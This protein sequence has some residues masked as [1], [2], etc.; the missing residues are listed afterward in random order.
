[1]A[2][3]GDRLFRR[4]LPHNFSE[5]YLIIMDNLQKLDRTTIIITGPTAAGK[6]D[7]AMELARHIPSEIINMDMGQMYTPLSIGTAKPEWRSHPIPHHMFDIIDTPS[8]YT[9][10]EYRKQVLDIMN[11]LWKQKKF[12]LVVGG[13]SFYLKSLFFPPDQHV[14]ENVK[15]NFSQQDEMW[16]HLSTPLLWQELFAIDPT[17]AEKIN[18]N[19]RYRIERA[20]SL[21]RMT[22]KKPSECTLNYMPPSSYILL[23]ITRDRKELYQRI[24]ARVVEM[25]RQGW[26]EEV[27]SLLE[28][29]W[30]SFIQNKKI[31][32]YNELIHFLTSSDQSALAYEAMIAEIQQRSRHYAKRQ[33]TFWRSLCNQLKIHASYH[34]GFK[35]PI[36][37]EVNLSRDSQDEYIKGIVS[38]ISNHNNEESSN[39]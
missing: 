32:G 36:I 3:I 34:N 26:L 16:S 23:Y 8:N 1:M 31:I 22:G 35:K 18:N 7:F 21:W 28:T 25:M 11:A 38:E 39:E 10:V 2:M 9:V 15:N 20:L 12:P 13:S 27:R 6:T 19:D 14:A 30:C 17:R 4:S 37:R 29:E 33:D 5:T 24:D